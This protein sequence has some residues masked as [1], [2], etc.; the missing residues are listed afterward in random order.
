MLKIGL[1]RE[2]KLPP[3]H[4]VAL[5]PSQCRWIM[6]HLPQIQIV[7]QPSAIRCYSN[8]EYQQAGIALQED[9]SDCHILMGIKEVPPEQLIPEKTYFFFSHTKKKQPH[10]KPLMQACVKKHITLI[11]YECLVHDDGQRMLGFGF[12]AGVVGAHN[13]LMAY[14]K[15]TGLFDFRR[16]YSCRD[17]Q[18]LAESYYGVKLPPLK[19][20]ITGSGRVAAGILEVMGLLG[21]KDITPEE[22]LINEYQ[23]PVYT[24]LKA[25]DLYLHKTERS[26]SR[27]HFHAHPKEYECKFLPFTTAADILMNGIYWEQ[28]MA[29]LFTWDDLCNPH[30]RIRVIADI[31]NDR[32]G[33]VP[34]NLGDS[35][36]EDPVY[37]VDRCTRQKLPPYLPHTVDMMCVGNL[38]DE[39]PRDASR[40]FGEQLIKYVIPELLQEQSVILEKATI[41]LNGKLTPRYSYLED[42]AYCS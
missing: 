40:Y 41:L 24:Q 37:G 15:K 6:Q 23:Y 5:T 17:L 25:G 12:F 11:D 29:P 33:S 35:T 16:A 4:R 26:Y 18:E 42:Y 7:V 36:I 3:D 30:F 27:E 9:L 13:G 10:N 8:E 28:S 1:I 22:F 31:T 21:I 32:E 34:C 20:A 38:P 19:I 14:G 2:G 39:L